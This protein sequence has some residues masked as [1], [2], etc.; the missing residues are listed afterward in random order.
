VGLSVQA[1]NGAPDGHHFTRVVG[2]RDW[3]EQRWC[4]RAVIPLVLAAVL[5][6]ADLKT[7]EIARRAGPAV[8]T[9][10]TTTASGLV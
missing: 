3:A 1:A 9:I 4:M 8:V 2:G 10:R 5:I 7:A 6:Q